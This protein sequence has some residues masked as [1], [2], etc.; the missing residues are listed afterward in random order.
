MIDTTIGTWLP[1]AGLDR[2]IALLRED[3]RNVIGPTLR[4]SAIVYDEIESIADLPTGVNDEQ[5]PGKY[6]VRKASDERASRSFDFASS[7][8]SWKSFT[9]PASV[10]IALARKEGEEVTYVDLEK[11]T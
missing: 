6:R 8:T 2:L 3:G 10:P 9:Y 7:P 1:R 4:D 5:A 11:D